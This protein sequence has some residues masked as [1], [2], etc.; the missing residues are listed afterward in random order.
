[1]IARASN[2]KAH[3]LTSITLAVQDQVKKAPVPEAIFT[4]DVQRLLVG[5][6]ASMQSRFMRQ[7]VCFC[8]EKR[9]RASKPIDSKPRTSFI[10][11]L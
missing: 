3:A 1:M 8:H 6:W 2:A 9:L 7:M 4:L 11:N 5:L 10:R